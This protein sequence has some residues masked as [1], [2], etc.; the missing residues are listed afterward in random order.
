MVNEIKIEKD[1]YF[2]DQIPIACSR[3]GIAN[4]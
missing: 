2:A 3:R 4:F 1:I